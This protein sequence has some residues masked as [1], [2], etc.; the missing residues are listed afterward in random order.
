[1][2]FKTHLQEI[3]KMAESHTLNFN[4]YSIHDLKQILSEKLIILK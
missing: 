1:L 2:I 3:I 4:D